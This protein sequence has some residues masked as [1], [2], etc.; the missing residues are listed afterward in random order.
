MSDLINGDQIE[1]VAEVTAPASQAG[2]PGEKKT[3]GKDISRF[4]AKLLEKGGFVK[5]VVEIKKPKGQQ[6]S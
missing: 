4:H 1:Y 5:P 2:K 6:N 3:V